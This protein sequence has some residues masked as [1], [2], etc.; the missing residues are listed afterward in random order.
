MAETLGTHA[1]THYCGM[2]GESLVGNT[3]TLMGWADTRRD[4]GGVVFIDLRDREGLCQVVARPEVSKDAHERADRVRGEYVLA[5]TGTVSKRSAETVNPKLATGAVEVL[6]SEIRILSEA[7]T[8]PF[9]IEDEV[10]TSEDIRLKYRY[11]DLRRPRMQRNIRLR[12]QLTMEIRRYLDEQ[13]FL[14]IETP[15][16]T[17]STPEGARDYLVPSRVHHGN[18]YA[19]PQSPQI[20][21][22]ILMVSGY[23][24][25]FQVARCFRD[26]DLRADRQPEFTQV[27]IEMSFPGPESIFDLIEPLYQRALALIGVEAPRPF[28]R[29]DYKTAMERYGSDKPDLRFEMPI[30]DVTDEMA[31]LGLDT[32]PQL[33]ADGPRSRA[34]VLPASGG[35]SGTRL[36]KINEELWLG[37]IVPD[38]RGTKRNLFTL[39]ATADALGNL[40]KKGASEAVAR[41]LLEKV[42]ASDDDT[43]LVGTDAPGPLAMAMGILRIEMGKELKLVDENA[44][45]FLWVTDFPLFEYDAGAKRFVSVNHPFTAPLEEDLHLLDSEPGR[46]RA[47]AYDI[48]LN[49]L[50]VGGG[51]FRI[52]DSALQ[53]KIFKLLSLSDEE[54]RER[55]GFFIEALQYGTPPHGG[56]ALGLDRLAMILARESSLRD[57]IEF[58]KTA[59]ATDLMSGSPSPVDDD[60]ISQLGVLVVKKP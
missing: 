26:E 39:K 22:Q 3:V 25:Y 56:I 51:S 8:P 42:G 47:K 20:F 58:P 13:G 41:T 50:E 55:F 38:S 5:V 43:V 46:V 10:N 15:F 37:R 11:I 6:A 57:V 27:D 24:K 29:L 17:K 28:P 48:V 30:T 45:R 40:A 54:T 36:R 9:P 19:L 34:N 12:H 53:A 4:L 60:Q 31:T 1:R 18:F 49:G 7:R 14:E 44:F 52:H 35:V 33:L 21:K 59:S 2:V 32:F 23:D 16:L